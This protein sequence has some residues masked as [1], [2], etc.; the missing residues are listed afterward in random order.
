MLFSR[1]SLISFAALWIL[2]LGLS[3][4]ENVSHENIDK[5]VNTQKGPGKLADVV[6]GDHSPDLRAHAAER[7]IVG[8]SDF[9]AVREAFES[10]P[11]G[12]RDAVLAELAPRL[13]EQARIDGVMAVP[14][15]PQAAAKDALFHLRTYADGRARAKIDEYLVEWF[16]GGHYEGRAQAGKVTGA[17]AMR[18]VGSLAAGRL[19]DHARS[20]AEAPPDDSGRRAQVGSETL[21]GLALTE[22]ADALS[23]LLSLYDEPRGDS[24]L[25]RRVI[26]ALHFAYVDARGFEP[27][28]GKA[29]VVILD[30]LEAIALD[31]RT[32]GRVVNDCVELLAATGPDCLAPLTRVIAAQ[33]PAK[34]LRWMGV[35]K[36]VR[37]GGPAALA[38][39]AQALPVRSH[40]ERGILERYLWDELSELPP[41]RGGRCRAF[42]ARLEK[43]G[44]SRDG[45]G[46]A[47][48]SRICGGARGYSENP[49]PCQGPESLAK[50]VGRPGR[51]SLR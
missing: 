3:S 9:E 23:F 34:A 11:G 17:M 31:E 19:L 27:A 16:T 37:C 28:D 42:L 6:R 22:S 29:L 26:D 10:M 4:C 48:R 18:K 38:P 51:G 43:L 32:P 40:Y 8:L 47:R 14:K 36:A 33:H 20:I 46:G 25:P 49:V 44:G 13:W 39:V 12:E 21:K 5:W 45:R 30:R 41:R 50:L 15:S 24:T 35:Q 1:P 7:L 2:A